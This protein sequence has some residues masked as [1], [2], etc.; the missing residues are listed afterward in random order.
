M[1]ISAIRKFL[2]DHPNVVKES[3]TTSGTNRAVIKPESLG[4]NKLYINLYKGQT[5]ENGVPLVAPA[6]VFV[7]HAWRYSFTD[8]IADPMEQHAAKDPNAYFW[9]ELFTN[10]QNAIA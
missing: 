1:H 9:F 7:S 8:T 5:G 4:T 2:A 6:T 10:D 3:L